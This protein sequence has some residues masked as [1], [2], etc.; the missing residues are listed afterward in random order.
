MAGRKRVY[1]ILIVVVLTIILSSFM[2][3]G[4]GG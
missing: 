1:F 4:V 2:C 3:L